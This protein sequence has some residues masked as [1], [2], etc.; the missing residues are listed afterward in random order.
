MQLY[1]LHI[2]NVGITS[3]VSQETHVSTEYVLNISFDR[4]KN[5]VIL[6]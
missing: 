1:G 3:T 5:T 6:Q 2:V 4:L